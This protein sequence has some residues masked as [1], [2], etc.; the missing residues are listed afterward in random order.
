MAFHQRHDSVQWPSNG[1]ATREASFNLGEK[2]ADGSMV[3]LGMLARRKIWTSKPVGSF[4]GE[5]RYVEVRTR[6]AAAT[7]AQ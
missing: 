4:G 7:N 5:V 3:S 1:S 2:T 6:F